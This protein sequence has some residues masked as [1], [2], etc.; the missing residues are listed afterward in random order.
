MLSQAKAASEG[1]TVPL[2]Q[3]EQEA[4]IQAKQ[5]LAMNDVANAGHQT[6]GKF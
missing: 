6:G 2:A 5:A 4:N 1:A 3:A